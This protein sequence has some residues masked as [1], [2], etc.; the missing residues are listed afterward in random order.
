MKKGK[1]QRSRSSIQVPGTNNVY[2]LSPRIGKGNPGV[3]NIMGTGAL[4]FY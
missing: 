3:I 2:N 4:I 1:P